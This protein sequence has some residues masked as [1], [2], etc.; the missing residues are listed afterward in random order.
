MSFNFNKNILTDSDLKILSN[1]LNIK[2][3][4]VAMK[5]EISKLQNG[6]YI[7]NL[8]NHN[9]SGSH[10]TAFIKNRKKIYYCDSFGI[11][12]PQEE[13]DL[14]KD[15]K[16]LIYYNTTQIQDINSQCCGY[17]ALGFLLY[18]KNNKGLNLNNFLEMFNTK[19]LKQNDIIIKNY[20]KKYLY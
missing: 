10:W 15:E 6:N 8:Q 3:N 5:D 16:D 7:L 12:M 14:F 9:Q 19:N 2:L 1:K 20:I 17:F 4:Q 11:I 13:L 18:S